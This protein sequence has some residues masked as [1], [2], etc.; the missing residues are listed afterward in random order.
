MSAPPPRP[1]NGLAAAGLRCPA[2]PPAF[3]LAPADVAA[4]EA[5]REVDRVDRPIGPDPR[6]GDACAKRRDVQPPPAARDEAAVAQRRAGMEDLRL[7]DLADPDR[8]AR[9]RSARIA[10]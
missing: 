10:L 4:A 8:P 6:L 9:V 2:S 3:H 5:A 7:A 1:L